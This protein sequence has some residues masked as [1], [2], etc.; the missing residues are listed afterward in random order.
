MDLSTYR[1]GLDAWLDERAEDLAPAGP[2]GTP[3][4]DEVAQLSRVKKALWESDWGRWGWPEVADGL[5]GS[6][7]LRAYL[8]EALM[9]RYLVAPNAYSMAEF[10][11]PTVINFAGDELIRRFVPPLLKGEV[12]WC[13]GFS[14]P[15]SGSNLGS[16]Q[17]RA[18]RSG[19]TWVVNG[20]K[21]WTSYA[22]FA[23]HCVLLARTG[24]PDSRHEG[25]SAFFVDM[26]SPGITVRP[27]RTMDGVE[28]FCEVFYDDVVVPDERMIGREGQ[29]WELAMSLLPL[30]RS[31]SLWHRGAYVRRELEHFVQTVPADLVA[32]AA[33]GQVALQLFALRSR[34]RATQ[35]RVAA[36]DQLGPETSV[37]KL[38]LVE[39]EQAV[40][41]VVL[42]GM[43]D[44][45]VLGDDPEAERWRS[46]F[47][48]SR[49]CSIYGGSMEIQRNILAQRVL[50]LG[51][52]R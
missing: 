21:V 44:D 26:D 28:E 17:C 8:G 3:L 40:F 14:E 20:Q 19:D 12:L 30:E 46:E 4:A 25:I 18:T 45:V 52:D 5:G 16:L 10:L 39:A 33:L 15:D 2:S 1:G 27:L 23:E 35:Y 6:V 22:Q 9:A 36:G 32:P 7:I 48:Y 34:S 42:D 47:I 37:D 49:A 31:T 24:G 38:L 50:G 43:A 11:A 51:K 13:Q 29:G 41:D